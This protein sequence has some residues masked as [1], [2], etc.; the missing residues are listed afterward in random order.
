MVSSVTALTRSGLRDWLVQRVTALVVGLYS[1]F[2]LTYLLLHP[3]LEY[4]GWQQLFSHP[5]IKIGTL[6]TLLC[7]VAHAWIGMWTVFTDYIKPRSLRLI[8]ICLMAL[9]LL[10]YLVWGIQIIWG[11]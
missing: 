5:I 11:L 8:V 3:Q 2:I 1:I 7:I 10:G 4:A 9:L 6:L